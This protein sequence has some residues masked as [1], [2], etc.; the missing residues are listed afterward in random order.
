M[1]I[2]KSLFNKFYNDK[3]VAYQNMFLV[4]FKFDVIYDQNASG[5]SSDDKVS[6]HVAQ[7]VTFSEH[8]KY[9]VESL[10]TIGAAKFWSVP[11]EFNGIN[12]EIKLEETN[13]YDVE[14]LITRIENTLSDP[15]ESIMLCDGDLGDIEVFCF[16]APIGKDENTMSN[17]KVK[18]TFKN[19]HYLSADN[20]SYGYESAATVMRS[21]SFVAESLVKTFDVPVDGMMSPTGG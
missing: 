17:A 18:Y 20:M 6:M 15:D 21:L 1:F 12:V 9:K 3:N 19:V 5:L 2:P 16:G 13:N 8:K 10:K 14:K 4:R 11:E 7:S